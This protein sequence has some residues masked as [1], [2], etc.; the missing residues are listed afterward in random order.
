[1][2]FPA[3]DT[4]AGHNGR[5][6]VEFSDHPEVI[7][8]FSYRAIHV[9]AVLGRQLVEACYQIKPE[10]SYHLGCSAGGRQAVQTA[11]LY[12]EDFDCL[13]GGVP[14]VNWSM[15]FSFLPTEQVDDLFLYI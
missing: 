7:N 5:T 3:I 15:L 12:P 13:V 6:G 9:E 10:K 2:H 4:N 11:M 14:A 1:M 8:D